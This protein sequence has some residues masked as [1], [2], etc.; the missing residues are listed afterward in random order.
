MPSFSEY[1]YESESK[2]SPEEKQLEKGINVEKEHKDLW[3]KLS[4]NGEKDLGMSEEE[5]YKMIAEA[6]LKELKDYYDRLEVMEREGKEEASED[7]EIEENG[8]AGGVEMLG[9]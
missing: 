7:D 9:F 4:D 8:D 6:H 5:F 3:D 1:F 2:E